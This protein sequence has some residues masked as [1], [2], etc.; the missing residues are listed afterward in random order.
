M[1]TTELLFLSNEIFP[2]SAKANCD[3]ANPSNNKNKKSIY[4]NELVF[5]ILFALYTP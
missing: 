5:G 2:D 3:I 1:L 4:Y